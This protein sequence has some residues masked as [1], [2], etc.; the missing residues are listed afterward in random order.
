MNTFRS[1][2]DQYDSIKVFLRETFEDY[3]NKFTQI[4]QINAAPARAD[5][6]L[7]K[8]FDNA[9]TYS[10]A[11]TSLDVYVFTFDACFDLKQMRSFLTHATNDIDKISVILLEN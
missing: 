2:F 6:V 11:D 10:N 1:L 5:L 3:K 4:S 8:I 7:R 9:A